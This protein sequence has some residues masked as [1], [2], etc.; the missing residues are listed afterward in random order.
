[1]EHPTRE[2]LKDMIRS[3]SFASIG[4]LFG[5]RDNTIRKWCKVYNLPTKKSVIKLI[6]DED[7]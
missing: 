4:K 6:N 1:M 5:V 2:E 3:E 7:W